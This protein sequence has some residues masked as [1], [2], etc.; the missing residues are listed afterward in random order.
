MLGDITI[1]IKTFLRPQKLD[2]CLKVIRRFYPDVKIIVA[3]DSQK[4]VD[5]KMADEYYTLPFDSG[6][7][8]GRNLLLSKITTPYMLLLDDDTL[9]TQGDCVENMLQ[10]ILDYPEINL[11]AGNLMNNK[12]H[13][14]YQKKGDELIRDFRGHRRTIGKYNIYDFVINL[15]IAKTESLRRVRWDDDLKICEHTNFFFRGMNELVCTIA[16]DTSFINDNKNN[17]QKYNRL[18]HDRIH[19]YQEKQFKSLGVTKF[20]DIN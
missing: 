14:T 20:V 4:P 19:I 9:F 12:Y 5:N 6:I 15:F 13:G 7:S 8:T 11:V 17:D 1:A 10:P 16:K 3:D 2:N 18:R